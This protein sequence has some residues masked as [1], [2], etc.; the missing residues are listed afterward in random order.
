M[1]IDKEWLVSSRLVGAAFGEEAHA[2]RSAVCDQSGQMQL[3]AP[4]PEETNMRWRF[5]AKI[6]DAERDDLLDSRASV[7]HARQ[8]RVITAAIGLWT[9][10]IAAS[11]AWISANSKYSTG[12]ERAPLKGTA[13][14]RW[15]C[16]M[17]SGCSKLHVPKDA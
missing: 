11:T 4:L 8:K 10:S 6:R 5:Q 3:L 7:E 12:R 13:K 14:T 9:R 15:Q 16:S 2:K 1:M 17:R